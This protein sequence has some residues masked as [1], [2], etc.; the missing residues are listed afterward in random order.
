MTFEFRANRFPHAESVP[1]DSPGQVQPAKRANAAP[2]SLDRN[3]KALKGRYKSCAP[4]AQKR[5]LGDDLIPGNTVKKTPPSFEGGVC[6]ES[7]VVGI[8]A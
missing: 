4:N 6:R 8:D 2:G 3:G 1:Y 7:S 5:M